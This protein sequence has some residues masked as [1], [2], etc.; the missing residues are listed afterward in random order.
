MFVVGVTGG[1]GSGKTAVSDRFAELGIDIVDADVVSRQVVLPGTRAL[2][3]IVSHVGAGILLPNGA[4][5]RAE[6]RARIFAEPAEKRWLE[7]LL[8]PLIGIEISAQL[9]AA[10]S[11]YVLFVS[12][13]LVETGQI[14]VCNR[15]VVVDVAES[16][17]IKRTCQRDGNTEE[18]V[19]NIL[20]AQTSREKRLQAATDILDN[21]GSLEQLQEKV[22]HL[23]R[24]FLQMAENSSPLQ[25]S[26]F[27]E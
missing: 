5:N 16:T 2:D 26:T 8:H 11:P 9:A 21:A 14:T 1:V 20:T 15:V 23:H 3:E 10:A 25:A 12:P 4:L 19:R 27:S 22:D 17:Q 7:Q 13:L 6:L 24:Q 18:Q